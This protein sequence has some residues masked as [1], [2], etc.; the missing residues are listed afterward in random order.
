MRGS[1]WISGVWIT[2]FASACSFS[3]HVP[4]N[5]GDDVGNGD[6]DPGPDASTTAP[7]DD[8]PVDPG[9]RPLYAAANQVLH[10]IDLDAHTATPIGSIAEAGRDVDLAGLAFDGTHLLGLT[11]NGVAMIRIDP[12][13]ASLISKKNLTPV[14]PWGGLTVVP[15]GELG[16][17][18]VI[19]TG[20]SSDPRLFRIDAGDGTVT[21]VGGYGN[22]LRF[23]SDL[24][25]VHGLGLIATLQG[26]ACTPVCF[27]KLDPAT[28]AATILRSTA[29]DS[30]YGL[31]GYRDQL[32][33]FNGNG[34][35]LAV[36]HTTFLMSV[37]FDPE[38][39]W[40]EAA[41]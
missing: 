15:A 17:A 9:S 34:P 22:G 20:N 25:W 27:A 12:Q 40:T 7:P 3:G 29:P 16:A 39:H 24:A 31:S 38:I 35:V 4:A 36:D 8:A 14:G 5:T 28:G 10:R 6:D 26:P 30:I 33:A 41:Q 32:W 21:A 1:S 23:F 2:L 37:A 13:T 19:F 11:P 18:P